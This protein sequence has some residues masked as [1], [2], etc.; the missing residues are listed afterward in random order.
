MT[1][2]ARLD[3]LR[4][5]FEKQAPPEALAVMHRVTADLSAEFADGPLGEGQVAPSF[6]LESS[7]GGRVALGDVLARG[8]AVLTFFRGHW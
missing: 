5:G 7:A 6:E 8:P 3:R 4:E 1:L 2:Q